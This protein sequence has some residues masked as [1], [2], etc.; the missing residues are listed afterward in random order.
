M[1]RQNALTI[2]GVSTASFPF[3]IIVED[4]PSITVNESKT[5]LIEHQGLTGAVLQTNPHRG[6]MELSYQLYLVK[7]SEEQLYSFL[8]LF[9]KE[10][11]WM[12]T[13]SFTTIR[14]WCYKAHH[15]PVQKD[16]L[17]VYETKVTFLCHPTKWFKRTDVQAF[18]TSGS[19][20]CQGSAISFP[21][22][23]ITGNSGGE[24]SFTVGDAVIRLE[25]LQET[26]IMENNPSQP[27]FR[28]QR[29]QPIKW[30]GDFISIDAGKEDSVGVVLG[31]GVT[32]LT[33]ETN[34]GWA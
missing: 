17:G 22:I 29:G 26:L 21:K 11:F 5:L 32:S 27:S 3:K 20:R 2:G 24:T 8:K 9:L 4:S 25:R 12:E 10:G 30:A 1:I 34:W 14:F 13:A 18:R 31:T 16:K 7:P 33:I 19:L 23:T 15:S 28:T 6:V